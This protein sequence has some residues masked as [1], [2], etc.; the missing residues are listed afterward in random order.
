M[1]AFTRQLENEAATLALGHEISLFARAGMTICLSGDL[2]AGKTTLARALIRALSDEGENLEVPSPTFALVQTYD[3]LRICVHHFDLYRIEDNNELYELGLFDDLENRL[4]LIEWP[5]RLNEPWPKDRIDISFNLTGNQRS[6]TI[7]GVGSMDKIVRRIDDVKQFLDQGKWRGASRFFLQGDASARRYERLVFASNENSTTSS[8]LMDMA[9]IPDGPMVGNGKTYSQIAHIAEGIIPVAAVNQNLSEFG[10]SAPALLQQNLP[11]GL[12]VIEDFGDQVFGTLMSN[13]I[14]ISEPIKVATDLLVVM[15]SIDWPNLTSAGNSKHQI[16]GF[17]QGTY[18]IE[19]SLLLDWFWP[20]LKSENASCEIRD[21]FFDAWKNPLSIIETK[22]PIW[23]LRDFHS[24]NLIWL[25]KRKGIKRVG[26]IDTQ[27]C[28][29]GHPAY[30]LVSMLQD[31]RVDLPNSF[32]AK[33]YQYYCQQ[34]QATNGDFNA[35]EF[36]TAYAV[37]GAQRATKI[38]GIFARLAKRDNKPGYL[39]H[40]ARVSTALERNLA[41]P[42]LS[43]LAKWYQTHLPMAQRNVDAHLSVNQ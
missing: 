8:I 2:G 5:D 41:H 27:D 43:E 31:A 34:R 42:A 22:S 7:C 10:F 20:F 40:I 28:V 13:G 12:M 9:D 39:R 37:L 3:E 6:A 30:D 32:E 21:S 19:I 17:D 15:A 35:E 24:P 18:E 14:D 26:L 1:V 29:F 4:T 33:Y 38:L 11:N 23:V 16:K 25:P 36:G